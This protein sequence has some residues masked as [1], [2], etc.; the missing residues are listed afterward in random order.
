MSRRAR[1]DGSSSVLPRTPP[2]HRQHHPSRRRRLPNFRW[3]VLGPVVPFQADP[4]GQCPARRTIQPTSPV[5]G[6]NAA[7]DPMTVI[8]GGRIPAA[9]VASAID[10]TVPRTVR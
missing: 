3:A 10:A 1:P 2:P 7:T 4:C 9:A 6:S 5:V 8:A